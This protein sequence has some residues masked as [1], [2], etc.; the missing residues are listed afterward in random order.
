MQKQVVK[1]NLERFKG[2][3][4]AQRRWHKIGDH[5]KHVDTRCPDYMLG[6]IFSG[7]EGIEVPVDDDGYVFIDRD[8]THFRLLSLS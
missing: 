1:E 3:N 5:F 6:T 4:Q 8:G 7:R 2:A